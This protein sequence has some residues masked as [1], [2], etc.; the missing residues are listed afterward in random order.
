[1]EEIIK[2]IIRESI[3][4]YDCIEDLLWSEFIYMIDED[5]ITDLKQV[6]TFDS[7]MD[8][9]D[10][11]NVYYK[12][13]PVIDVANLYILILSKDILEKEFPKLYSDFKA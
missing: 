6:I 2:D 1:M 3:K 10:S 11:K 7:I 4:K 13:S 5:A 9:L 8:Y 12:G